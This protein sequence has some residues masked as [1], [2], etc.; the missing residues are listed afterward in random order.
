M[1]GENIGNPY[2]SWDY[3][4]QR[5]DTTINHIEGTI[6]QIEDQS[7]EVEERTGKPLPEL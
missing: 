5:I 3:E 1:G 4:G 6:A 2:I 7:F